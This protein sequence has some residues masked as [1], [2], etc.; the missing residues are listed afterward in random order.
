MI[1]EFFRGESPTNGVKAFWSF[2]KRCLARFSG[3]RDENFRWP[4]KRYITH[5]WNHFIVN[6]RSGEVKKDSISGFLQT[7]ICCGISLDLGAFVLVDPVYGAATQERPR[8]ISA[9]IEGRVDALEPI[10]G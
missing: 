4:L 2:V 8:R 5:A 1:K 7:E 3:L 9:S 10:C 6:T